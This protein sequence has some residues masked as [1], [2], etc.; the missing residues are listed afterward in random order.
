MFH[1][2]RVET[3]RMPGCNRLPARRSDYC[4][5]RTYLKDCSLRTPPPSKF[6][7]LSQEVFTD[8]PCC[9]DCCLESGCEKEKLR[10][11]EDRGY[12]GTRTLA[13]IAMTYPFRS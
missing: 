6:F 11:D 2:N 5:N 4:N 3:C 8:I 9:S 10:A 7:E 1:V 13:T 12:C